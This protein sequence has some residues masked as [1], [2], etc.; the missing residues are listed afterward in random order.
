[1][2]RFGSVLFGSVR[3]EYRSFGIRY[4]RYLPASVVHCIQR[5]LSKKSWFTLVS[6]QMIKN[7][8]FDILGGH[9]PLQLIKVYVGLAIH[10]SA[11]SNLEILIYTN[12][13][14]KHQKYL[15]CHFWGLFTLLQLSKTLFWV[16]FAGFAIH[17]SE[18]SEP[19][20][21]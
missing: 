9:S 20:E 16:G 19:G 14:S 12:L 3:L 17:F 4:I 7:K 21:P 1:M 11:N 10:Y 6:F 13:I 8:H 2:I 5:T 18:P 15:F